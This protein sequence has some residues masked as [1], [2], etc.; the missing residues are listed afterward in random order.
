MRRPIRA[1]AACLALALALLTATAIA[2]NQPVPAP[3]AGNTIGSHQI[4]RFEAIR[5]LQAA[6][7]TSP[8]HVAGW[9]ILGELAHEVALDL[10]QEQDDPYYQLSRVAYERALALEPNNNG[11]RAAVQFAKDQEANAVNFDAQRRRGVVAYL[12]ARRA[13]MGTSGINPTVLVYEPPAA[14]PAANPAAGA[15]AAPA[16]AAPNQVQPQPYPTPTYRPFYNAQSQQPYGYNQY[17]NGYAPPVNQAAPPTTLRQLGQQVPGAIFNQIG[18]GAGRG[19][20][21]R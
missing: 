16:Q 1:R 19:L 13:E 5:Q 3:P 15:I 2:Q 9:V 7:R 21:P 4:D 10:P 18:G 20:I 8:N 12:A 14:A 6:T 17:Q 11:L